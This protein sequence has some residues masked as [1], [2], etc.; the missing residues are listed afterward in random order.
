MD[1]LSI[2]M[3]MLY[4]HITKVHLTKVHLILFQSLPPSDQT[5]C[6]GSG[7]RGTGKD[8][9]LELCIARKLEKPATRCHYQADH[10]QGTPLS[11]DKGYLFKHLF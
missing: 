4:M 10:R 5:F 8:H 1:M 6:Q 3:D 11:T 2:I 7:R 9:M